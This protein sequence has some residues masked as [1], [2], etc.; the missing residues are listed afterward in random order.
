[1]ENK[2]LKLITRRKLRKNTDWFGLIKISH[3]AHKTM[4]ANS[5]V[6]SIILRALSC[7]ILVGVQKKRKIV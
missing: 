3:S 5:N 6:A 7:F 1:M 4:L 2:P